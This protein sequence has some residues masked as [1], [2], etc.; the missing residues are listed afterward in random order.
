MT[1]ADSTWEIKRRK[2]QEDNLQ[3]KMKPLVEFVAELR[4][5]S[6]GRTVPNFDPADGSEYIASVRSTPLRL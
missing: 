5:I 6:E 1:V 4:E 3:V 2:L